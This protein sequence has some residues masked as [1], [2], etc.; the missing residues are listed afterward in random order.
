MYIPHFPVDALP[1]SF[2]RAKIVGVSLT[3]ICDMGTNSV[4]LQA[5]LSQV[6]SIPS[7]SQAS[8]HWYDIDQRFPPME[9]MEYCETLNDVVLDK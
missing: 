3:I 1:S 8:D 5:L 4:V 6:P 7:H 2:R 9:T